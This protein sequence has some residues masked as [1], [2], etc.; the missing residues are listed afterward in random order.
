MGATHE[1]NIDTITPL[2]NNSSENSDSLS[3]DTVDMGSFTEQPNSMET[4]ATADSGSS[5]SWVGWIGLGLSIVIG[6]YA[7]KITGRIAAEV[8]NLRK[9]F[10]DNELKISQKLAEIDNLGHEIRALRQSVD[11]VSR[12]VLTRGSESNVNSVNQDAT[13]HVSDEMYVK[14]QV[15]VKYATL[16]SPDENGILRFSER[17]MVD[18][19]S[20]Q[21][22]FMIEIDNQ[23]GT[24][25]YKI[26]PSA[27]NLI[28]GDLLMFRDFVKPFT[29][30]GNPLKATIQDRKPGKITRRG[31]YWVVEEPL[32]ISI[33]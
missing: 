31:N 6:I 5:N 30:S 3:K 2:G 28:L 10:S 27:I 33:Y 22:M 11:S 9:Q 16:Q 4:I 13:M 15:Q 12:P 1:I 26:N 32:E 8:K 23:S 17:S 25:L 19:A 20:P 21:K 18:I 14:Q 29:F 7:W 24:G